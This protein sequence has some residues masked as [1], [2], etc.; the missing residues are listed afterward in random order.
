MESSV[1]NKSYFWTVRGQRV[2]I[3]KDV[4]QRIISENERV[5]RQARNEQRCARPN[6]HYCPGDCSVCRFQVPGIFD[7]LSEKEC[8]EMPSEKPEDC[9]EKAIIQ[10]LTLESV[11]EHAD[12]L[13][14]DGARIL[15]LRFMC[16][17]NSRQIAEQLGVSH[18]VI[19]RR[20]TRLMAYF[21]ANKNLF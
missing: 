20:L 12:R 1:E 15:R 6:C 13:V 5:R 8:D 16:D 17:M 4:Y 7:E 21:Q 10:K 19:N 3:T 14:Q 2:E 18:T 11:F 9:V